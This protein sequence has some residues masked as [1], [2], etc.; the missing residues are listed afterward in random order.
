MVWYHTSLDTSNYLKVLETDQSRLDGYQTRCFDSLVYLVDRPCMGYPSQWMSPLRWLV[1]VVR[2]EIRNER[3]GC[4]RVVLWGCSM[5]A[6]SLTTSVSLEAMSP[7]FIGQESTFCTVVALVVVRWKDPPTRRPS[8]T[9]RQ[10]TMKLFLALVAAF[11]ASSASAFAPVMQSRPV[12]TTKLLASARE[13]E[14][15]RRTLS[16]VFAAA[17]VASNVVTSVLPAFAVDDNIDFGSSE[18]VAARSGGRSGGRASSGGNS[19]SYRSSAPASRST[20]KSYSSTTYVAP[21]SPTILV[22]PS[23]GLGYSYNPLGGVA[24]GYALGTLGNIGNSFQDAR[25]ER[26]IQESRYELEQARMREAELEGRLRALE[27][28]QQAPARAAP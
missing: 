22:T 2:P 23:Y 10:T 14:N 3:Q 27:Q 16:S 26:E 25:Q 20:Y 12:T 1:L 13:D 4:R 18:V 9:I 21:P 7:S 11:V 17:F 5:D 8:L 15:Y 24:T 28:Q 19:R 6:T